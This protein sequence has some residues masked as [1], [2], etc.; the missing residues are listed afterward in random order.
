MKTKFFK[1]IGSLLTVFILLFGVLVWH[2]ADV[3]KPL[4]NSNSQMARIE[5]LGDDATTHNNF[6][7]NLKTIEGVGNVKPFLSNKSVVFTYDNTNTSSQKIKD[8]IS[9]DYTDSYKWEI[10][11]ND[12]SS[13]ACPIIR[14][15]GWKYKMA[16]VVKEIFY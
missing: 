15:D 9:S 11:V 2:L 14:R 12:P 3:M 1:I 13:S 7:K 6:I 10:P 16:M 4:P 5:L 8:S